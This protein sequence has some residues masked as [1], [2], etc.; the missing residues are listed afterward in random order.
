MEFSLLFFY[1]VISRFQ[2]VAR[3]I[4]SF[5]IYF[6]LE[7]PILRVAHKIVI[8]LAVTFTCYYL[9]VTV[10][11]VVESTS[12]KVTSHDFVLYIYFQSNTIQSC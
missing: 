4:I 3:M 5:F 10:T 12:N 1:V 2:F 11:L 6:T 9:P 7:M 8:S